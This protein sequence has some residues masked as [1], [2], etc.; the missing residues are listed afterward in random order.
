VTINP[1]G[2]EKQDL[3]QQADVFLRQLR[4]Q[5]KGGA[6][7][8]ADDLLLFLYR[9]RDGYRIVHSGGGRFKGPSFAFLHELLYQL[10]SRP[11]ETLDT[12]E[13]REII[14][15][16]LQELAS[17]KITLEKKTSH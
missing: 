1:S 13:W 11:D 15:S 4:D 6:A 8:S 17:K 2:G 7:L 3:T 10:E 14:E 12:A 5:Q 9:L 16:F